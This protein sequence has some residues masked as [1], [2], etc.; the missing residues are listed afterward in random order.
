LDEVQAI[1]REYQ[2]VVR[3]TL[4]QFARRFD[5]RFILLTATKPLIFGPGQATEL[6]PS[7]QRVFASFDRYDIHIRLPDGEQ[8]EDEVLLLTDNQVHGDFYDR[9][10]GFQGNGCAIF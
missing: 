2:E 3:D 1:P 4:D 6:L 10:V 5:S 7:H 9:D 8:P